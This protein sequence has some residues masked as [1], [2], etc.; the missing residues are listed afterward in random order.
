MRA[1]TIIEL[2]FVIV[3]LGVLAAIALPRFAVIQDDAQIS[4][5][6]SGIG[7]VRSSIMAF[8]GKAIA[9]SGRE[10]NIT[11]F[12]NKSLV[13]KVVYPANTKVAA[14]QE[15]EENLSVANYP[16]ALSVGAW[17]EGGANENSATLVAPRFVNREDAEKG[18]TALAIA[19]EPGGRGDFSTF[20]APPHSGYTPPIISGGSISY[21]T[22]R[23]AKNVADPSA[24]PCFGKFWVYNSASGTIAIAGKCV[25][26]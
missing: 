15:G 23:A 22:G 1:F 5:E 26:I 18:S 16:N 14:N 17:S 20:S 25:N 9:R 13:Y 11:I 3:I 8:R 21:I 24:D 6:K 4:V 10:L 7:S 2:I 12:D 19:L